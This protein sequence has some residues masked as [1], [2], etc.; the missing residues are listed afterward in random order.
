MFGGQPGWTLK[1][2]VWVDRNG[3]KVLG[4]GRADLLEHIDRLRSISAAARQMNMSY[5]R[6]WSL[7]RAMNDAAGEPLVEAVTG[8]PHGGGAALTARGREALAEYRALVA[9][10][11]DAAEPTITRR[12]K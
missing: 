6:A 7:V 10:L 8:G 3:V 5:R 12:R 1:V 4:P 2:R 9:R 11:H